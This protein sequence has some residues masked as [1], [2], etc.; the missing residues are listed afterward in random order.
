MSAS[1]KP[2]CIGI[3]V[4]WLYML[5]VVLP[6]VLKLAAAPRFAAW[7]WLQATAML[8]GPWCLLGALSAIGWVMARPGITAPIASATN[9]KQ[10]QDITKSAELRLSAED[11]GLLNKASSY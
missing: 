11:M 6:I 7:S 9:I 1:S 10:L 3:L 5:L 2:G 4:L 8:W